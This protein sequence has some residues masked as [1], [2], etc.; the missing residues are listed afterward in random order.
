MLC[1]SMAAYLGQGTAAFL[2]LLG[3]SL[4]SYA[5]ALLIVRFPRYKKALLTAFLTATVGALVALKY[6]DLIVRSVSS[7][8]PVWQI[9]PGSHV[10]QMAAPLGISFFTLMSIA[11]VVDVYNDICRPERNPFK[12]Y[13]GM[14]FFPIVTSG[15]IERLSSLLPQISNPQPLTYDRFRR[16]AL[17][18]LWGFFK[19]VVIAD[20]IGG[21]VNMVFSSP[22]DYE[23]ILKVLAAVLFSIQ[24]YCDFSAYSDIAVGVGRW[25]GLDMIINFRTPYFSKSVKEYWQRNHISLSTWFRD[26]LFVPLSGGRIDMVHV[27]WGLLLVFGISGLWH[28]ASWTFLVWGLLH[29]V[30]IIRDLINERRRRGKKNSPGWR[31][32]VWEIKERV[33]TLI[34]ICIS[35]VFFRANSFYDAFEILKGFPGM[36]VECGRLIDAT[37]LRPVLGRIGLARSEWFICIGGIAAWIAVEAVLQVKNIT[38]RF[39]RQP[40]WVRWCCYYAA[41]AAGLLLGSFNQS[42]GFIY[43][44]F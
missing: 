39:Y 44:Q 34:L 15:P 21:V 32:S 27:A 11:Y 35:L 3:E 18:I 4:L 22:A 14:S 13:L 26:Y 30:Y 17:Y 40:S 12:V 20:R 10:F 36:A 33:I 5:V 6:A 41:L 25:L 19:K 16:G 43:Q 42:Q 9:S 7:V 31:H 23:P 28:G 38:E 1:A 29:G 2:F 8:W 37:Y 24:V